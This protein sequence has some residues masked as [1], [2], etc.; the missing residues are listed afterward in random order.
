MQSK[1]SSIYA[2]HYK[3]VVEELKPIDDGYGGD[4]DDPNIDI[5][6]LRRENPKVADIMSIVISEI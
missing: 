3:N 4:S 5:E 2:A 1:N 6:D